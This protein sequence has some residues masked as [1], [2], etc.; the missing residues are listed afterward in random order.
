MDLNPLDPRSIEFVDERISDVI[1]FC[2]TEYLIVSV[3]EAGSLE[4]GK[5]KDEVAKRGKMVVY[6]EYVNKIYDLVTKKYNKLVRFS[7]D[8]FL[9]RTATDEEILEL[10]KLFPKNAI[11]GDWGYESEY[12]YHRFERNNRLLQ[13]AG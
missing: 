13:Q 7:G 9:K 5:S 10:L 12:E 2:D 6:M 11:A 8:M 4:T 3:D 1:D